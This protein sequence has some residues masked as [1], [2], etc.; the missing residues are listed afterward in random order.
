MITGSLKAED[1]TS[2]AAPNGEGKKKEASVG[3]GGDGGHSVDKVVL[4]LIYV[5]L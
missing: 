5:L 1:S 2:T 3:R 4:F